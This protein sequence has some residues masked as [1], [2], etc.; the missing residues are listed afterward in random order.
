ML[1]AQCLGAVPVPVYQDAVAEEMLFVLDNAETR[2]AVAE[3][4]EQ[5]DKLLEHQGRLPHLP[6]HLLRRSARPAPLPPDVSVSLDA[7]DVGGGREFDAAQ[8]DF[9]DARG[10]KGRADDV[11]VDALYLGNDG[12]A[13]RA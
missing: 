10:A 8:P 12:Q 4:Q 1:A 2:F 3:D 7:A 6:T 5:V 11:S 9:F 13:Q